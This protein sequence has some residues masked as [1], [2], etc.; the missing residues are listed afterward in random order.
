MRV[1]WQKVLR[2]EGGIVMSE[3][4][5]NNPSVAEEE[6]IIQDRI[7]EEY[8][9]R[10]AESKAYYESLEE[11]YYKAMEKQQWNIR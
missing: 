7:D 5:L 3:Y 11:A 6:Q 9:M 2:K 4:N 8:A 1:I 10:E